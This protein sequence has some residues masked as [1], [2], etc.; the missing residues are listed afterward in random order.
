VAPFTS[1]PP[2]GDI[3]SL[4]KH[5]INNIIDL[6]EQTVKQDNNRTTLMFK[7]SLQ[8]TPKK[9]ESSEEYWKKI[10]AIQKENKQPN[11]DNLMSFNSHQQSSFIR[12]GDK[13]RISTDYG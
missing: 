13:S 7:N 6:V 3:P 9:Q 12:K 8:K 10:K 1:L 2:P 5:Q 4:S 11:E